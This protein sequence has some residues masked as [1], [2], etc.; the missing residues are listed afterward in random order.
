MLPLLGSRDI[1]GAWTASFGSPYLSKMRG[2]RS[3]LTSLYAVGNI[4]IGA[5]IPRF[6]DLGGRPGPALKL[7]EPDVMQPSVFDLPRTNCGRYVRIVPKVAGLVKIAAG[8]GHLQQ[9]LQQ[10]GRDH[11]DR[12]IFELAPGSDRWPAKVN[13]EAERT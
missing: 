10:L 5:E 9:Q 6:I 2:C 12:R 13:R 3:C 11:G 1:E 8:N 7:S 4:W